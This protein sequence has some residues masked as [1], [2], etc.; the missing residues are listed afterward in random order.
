[1]P[2]SG[3]SRKTAQISLEMSLGSEVQL[4]S[5]FDYPSNSASTTKS[6]SETVIKTIRS[7]FPETWLFQI[8]LAEYLKNNLLKF[9]FKLL[10]LDL[11]K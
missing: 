4:S 11:K 6:S 9:F 5:Q 1:M 3:F 2:R 8:D 7:N 10:D